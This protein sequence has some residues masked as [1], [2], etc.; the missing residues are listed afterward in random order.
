MK[1]IA[2]ILVSLSTPADRAFVI[3]SN[4]DG[5]GYCNVIWAFE[6]GVYRSRAL[7]GAP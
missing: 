1:T 3:M 5:A 7:I 4:S 6:S 2:A